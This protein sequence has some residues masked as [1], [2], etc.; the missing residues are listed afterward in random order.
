MTSDALEEFLQ[1]QL[2]SLERA[3][4]D[5]TSPITLAEVVRLCNINNRPLPTWASQA[6]RYILLNAKIRKGRGATGNSQAADRENNK[7]YARWDAVTEVKDRWD[8]IAEPGD[9]K[10]S[11]E[12]AYA[13][14]G[15]VR[16]VLQKGAAM[17]LV[18]RLG[19][20]RASS[21]HD[22]LPICNHRLIPRKTL[23][24]KP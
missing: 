3:W 12:K 23:H 7:Q 22:A 20:E 19:A 8:E 5:G 17:M 16:Q 2:A 11:L 14:A 6:L 18:M 4:L 9:G 10:F 21:L 13:K 1:R 24:N 15:C